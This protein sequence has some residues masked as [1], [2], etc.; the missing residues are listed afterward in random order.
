MRVMLLVAGALAALMAVP[1]LAQTPPSN[2]RGKVAKVDGQMLMVKSHGKMVHVTMAPNFTVLGVSKIN[3][4]DIKAGDFVG[5]AALPGKDGK[6]HAQEVLVFPEAA[7]GTGEGHYP[8]DLK[9]EGDTMTNATVAE[10]ASPP[11]GKSRVLKLKYKGGEQEI[12]VGT[13]TPIVTFA[14]DTTDL[15]KPGAAIF[16]RAPMNP[17][18]SVTAP[19]AIVEKNGVKPPM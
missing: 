6:L 16:I 18:G 2:L 5:V 12:T 1:A 8:W 13:R 10:V 17:D 19:R 9:G 7:R 15:L 4:T 3:L 11:K 14:P